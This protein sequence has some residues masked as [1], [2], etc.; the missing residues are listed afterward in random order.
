MQTLETLQYQD[1]FVDRHIGPD[2]AQIQQMLAELDLT[3]LDQLVANTVPEAISLK[4][5]LAL[6]EAQ[7]ES[8]ALA[9]LKNMAALNTPTPN[10][11]TRRV[12]R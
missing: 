4:K 5:P 9:E 3:S 1:E 2:E 6:G 12:T 10:G 8:M 7:T 11:C